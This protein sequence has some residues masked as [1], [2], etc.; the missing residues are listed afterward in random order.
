MLWSGGGG[1]RRG[2]MVSMDR[3]DRSRMMALDTHETLDPT[4]T[5]A[6]SPLMMPLMVMTRGVEPA[7]AERRAASVVTTVAKGERMQK[8]QRREAW[9]EEEEEEVEQ[10]PLTSSAASARGAAVHRGVAD[11]S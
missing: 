11:G 10:E 9:K 6:P 1:D 3:A 7:Q 2:V 5:T 8:C 4:L